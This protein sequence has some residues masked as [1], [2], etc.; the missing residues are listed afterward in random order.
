[1]LNWNNISSLLLDMDGTLLDLNFDNYFWL[2]HLPKRYA[3]I[4]QQDINKVKP[5]LIEQIMAQ[6]GKLNWYSLNF[7]NKKFNLN[8]IALKQEVAHLIAYRADALQFL[9]QL[10]NSKFKVILATNADL[11][12]LD[13]KLPITDLSSWVD[14]I[15]SSA[16][17]NAPKEEASYWQQLVDAEQLNPETCLLID[18]N[19][20]VLTSAKQFGIGHLLSIRQPDT[21]QTPRNNSVF[22]AINQFAEL[23]LADYLKADNK[24][25]N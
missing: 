21:R 17:F 1:M 9:Q 14:N 22:P 3:E 4:H 12:S 25:A 5:W 20:C 13:L 15:Y 19:E 23:K 11:P 7:W 18:D 6:K 24:Q 10:K 2:E 16:S 8:L